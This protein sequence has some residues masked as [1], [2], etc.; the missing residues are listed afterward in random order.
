MRSGM[1]RHQDSVSRLLGRGFD[2]SGGVL[3]RRGDAVIHPALAA[4]QDD[5]RKNTIA[6]DAAMAAKIAK[7]NAANAAHWE[8]SK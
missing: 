2:I 3:V 6:R 8:A 1:I 7:I 5:L 4:S